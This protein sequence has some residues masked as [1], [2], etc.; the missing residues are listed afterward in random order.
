MR[1]LLRPPLWSRVFSIVFIVVWL[2]IVTRFVIAG[3]DAAGRLIGVV[4]AVFGILVTYRNLRTGVDGSA[5]ELRVRNQVR[6]HTIARSD[7]E[8]FRTGAPSAG[9]FGARVVFV[10]TSS[11]GVVGA[12]VT[13]QVSF[14]PGSQRRLQE[15]LGV[16]ERWLAE[17]AT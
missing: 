5:D 6:N 3:D 14:L 2:G 13:Q 12:L 17:P 9:G 7:I 10:V 11:Q 15:D 8:G 1:P 4:F 16:L